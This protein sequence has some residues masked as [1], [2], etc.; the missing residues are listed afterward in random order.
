MNKDNGLLRVET[1]DNGYTRIYNVYVLGYD[2]PAAYAMQGTALPNWTREPA[3]VNYTSIGAQSP[4]IV[5]TIAS[6][7]LEA[8]RQAQVWNKDTGTR[9]NSLC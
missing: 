7:I 4:E 5:T 1:Q 3:T 2:F 8:A 6:A 9:N